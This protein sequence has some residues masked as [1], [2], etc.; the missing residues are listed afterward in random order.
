MFRC[1]SCAVQWKLPLTSGY[2]VLAHPHSTG[3]K[4]TIER[5]PITFFSK[6]DDVEDLVDLAQKLTKHDLA[7]D[8]HGDH[9]LTCPSCKEDSKFE[10]WLKAHEHPSDFFEADQLCHCGGELWWDRVPGKP[11]YALICDKCEWVKP[12]ARLSGSASTTEGSIE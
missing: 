6:V 5:E 1:P 3:M 8:T 11:Q 12:K 4:L 2:S 9:Y 10:E 7:L